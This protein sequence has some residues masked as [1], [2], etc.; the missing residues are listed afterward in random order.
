[1]STRST[2]LRNQVLNSY[3]AL[4]ILGAGDNPTLRFRTSTHADL[5]V[6]L[7]HA[8]IPMD[9]ASSGEASMLRPSSETWVDYEQSPTAN[10]TCTEVCLCDKDGTV[11]ETFSVGE[12]ESGEEFIVASVVFNTAIPQKFTAAPKVVQRASYDPTP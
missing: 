7:L 11:H 1:M 3:N 4:L 8:T 9:T 12:A 6:V 2:L 5:M 10:G